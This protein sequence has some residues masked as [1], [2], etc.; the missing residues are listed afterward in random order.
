MVAVKHALRE[1]GARALDVVYPPDA[2][3]VTG[4]RWIDA[5]C[6]ARCGL[7]FEVSL[8]GIGEAS[9]FTCGACEARSP[10]YD[11]ARAAFAYD[12]ASRDLVLSFK[13]AGRTGNLGM[14]ALQMLRAGRE[15]LEGADAL[16]PV[17]LHRSRLRLRRFNQSALLANRLAKL[18]GVEV[19]PNLL[20]RAKKT[21]SQ[22]TK[23]AVARRRNVAGAFRVR[24][25]PPAHCVL[26]DDVMTTGATLEA[27]AYALRRAGARRVDA[28]CL[29][30][31]VRERAPES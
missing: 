6:C 11:R 19:A 31:V 7:P 4:L 20:W 25:M 3:D 18:S 12:D 13:H 22:G 1:W 17:P 26:V 15:V 2:I 14:F 23:S 28:V 8:A 30:R 29:A 27:C 10:R 24:G 5:P 9:E 21:E 16:V